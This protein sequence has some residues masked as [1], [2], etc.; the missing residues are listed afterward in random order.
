MNLIARKTARLAGEIS[1]PG[2]KSHTIRGVVM[3]ALANGTSRLEN[4]LDSA[5][6]L[7]AFNAAC[8][9]GARID[10]SRPEEWFIEGF[11][12][13]PRPP[14]GPINMLNSGTSTN[15][16]A[17]VAALGD[18][19]V[20]IDGDSSI[21]KRPVQHL[22]NALQQ[23]GV[24][25]ESIEKNG[26]P[27]LR[28]KGPLRGGGEAEVECRSSQYVSSLLITCPLIDSDQTTI[29]RVRNLCEGPYIEMT[30]DWLKALGI[31]WEQEG[32]EC[33]R[34]PGGQHY[35]PFSREIPADWSSATFP[36]CAAAMIKGS[37]CLIKGLD[38]NDSQADRQVL[39]HLQKMGAHI[40]LNDQGI[41]VCGEH[42]HGA[43][44]DLNNTPDALPAMAAAACVAEG[45]TVI[46]NVAHARI[47]ETDRIKVMAEEL[48]RMGARIKETPDGLIIEESVLHGAVVQGHHD[49]RVVMALSLAAM[50]A[51]GTTRITTAGAVNVTFPGYVGL[52]QGLGAGMEMMDDE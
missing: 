15:L 4:P 18:F 31:R 48:G 51:E 2:S 45:V 5:D 29:I 13:H 20:I 11:G 42:L 1:I 16:F 6:T 37:D 47:K 7:A 41:R 26:C 24:K 36:L 30:L 25:A 40:E 35:Q 49:H 43:E 34:I 9:L 17:S 12:S 38:I 10:S 32:Y 33:F 46:K 21:R 52:M 14:A 27:P 22:L 50:A 3:A 28:I 19:E 23:L 8:A 39:E 44:L